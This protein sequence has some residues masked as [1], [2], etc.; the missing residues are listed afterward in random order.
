[1][2]DLDVTV[3]YAD[4]DQDLVP[5]ASL[6]PPA[7][8][9]V[10]K[11]IILIV[12]DTPA[13]LR[14]LSIMLAKQG[15]K[16]R[17][18]NSGQ[19]ALESV[20]A[21]P[22]DLILLDIMMPE[23]SGYEVCKR[24][25]SD[26]QTSDIPVIFLSALDATESKVN[27]FRTGGIDYITKPFQLEEVVARVETHLA[28]YSLQK[29]L[30]AQNVQLEREVAERLQ[31]EETMRRFTERLQLLHEI[32]Q[33]ILGAQ[34]PAAIAMAILGRISHLVP[35]QRVSVVE[36]DAKLGVQVLAVEA[37]RGFGTDITACLS[38]LRAAARKQKLI[39]GVADIAALPTR[40]PLQ[41]QLQAEGVRSYLIVPLLAQD[42]VI[43]TLNL[44]ADQPNVFATE[45]VEAAAQVAGMLA[46]AIRQ[47]QLRD[48]LSQR[49]AELEAQ[50][51]ELDAF[52]HTVAHD[53]KNPLAV[54]AGNA[55][56]LARYGSTMKTEDLQRIA[57]SASEGVHKTVSIVDN[58]LLLA[59]AHKQ[60]VESRVLDMGGI[61]NEVRDRL[62]IVIQE[63]QPEIIVPETW[64]QALG[65]A[66]W[67]EEVWANYLSNALKYGGRPPRVELGHSISNFEI[68]FW[69]R[70]NGRGLTPEEQSHL[71]TP[72]ER[73]SQARIEG[74]GLG[75][76]IVQ[77]I[78]HKLGGQV[79]VESTPGQGS[80]FY[81][82]LLAA[83]GAG[84]VQPT[85]RAPHT[86]GAQPAVASTGAE[87]ARQLR[88][89]LV[90]DSKLSREMGLRLLGQLG[91]QVDAASNGL[92]ALEAL[93]QRAYDLILMDVH[94][95]DMD[96]LEATRAIRQQW[97][98]D[99]QPPIVAMTADA[100]PEDWQACLEAGMNSYV[101]KPMQITELRAVL[102][103]WGKSPA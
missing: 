17:V 63:Y 20:Q 62:S 1:M 69:V 75:L 81:F 51:A 26:V 68:K 38:L 5:G 85:A 48:S 44:E 24:L 73:L 79:G 35:C 6:P 40:S 9:D 7:E 66:P 87:V 4:D 67:I 59:S 103:R 11:G 60:T 15:H 33:A 22:P 8:L 14:L 93:R 12:D 74:H 2:N 101:S 64:P 70:D 88:V 77:R 78:V 72:F 56:L 61:V 97:P 45:H 25:K 3:D 52:A 29:K 96:G 18:A 13:N 102:E 37:G 39:Q 42:E 49:T 83:S 50:N 36:F 47:A 41:E 53:L 28:L 31:I 32:D 65:Y 82:T 98:P 80:V 76:S 16:V 95:P 89:L 91:H 43:G 94:M 86:L 21:N 23:M 71:F 92:E 34:S 57:L 58:L 99:Q 10:S 54:I 84:A 90:E 19:R 27:A 30:Q 46:V 55:E 100:A